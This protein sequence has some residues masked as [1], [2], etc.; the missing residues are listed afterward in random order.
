[1]RIYHSGDCLAA[2]PLAADVRALVPDLALLPINGRDRER[3]DAGLVGNMNAAVAV[4]FAVDI[5]ARILIP[6]HYDAFRVNT[7]DPTEVHV[8]AAGLGRT[9]PEVLVP[10]REVP[11]VIGPR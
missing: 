2:A 1:M 9:A 8:L 5:G 3:E 4:Q 7:A 6:M 11:V 10:T